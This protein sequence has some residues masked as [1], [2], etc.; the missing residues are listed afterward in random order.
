MKDNFVLA[1]WRPTEMSPGEGIDLNPWRFS[2]QANQN[3][4]L[5][6]LRRRGAHSIWKF[7]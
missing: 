4:R 5:V 6:F 7:R 3:D 2:L 1:E